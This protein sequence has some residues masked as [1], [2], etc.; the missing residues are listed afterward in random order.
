MYEIKS[1]IYRNGLNSS[2]IYPL[3]DIFGH[4]SDSSSMGKG[5][6]ELINGVLLIL[7][8]IISI[9]IKLNF[10]SL[11]RNKK[12][13]AHIF[14]FIYTI[15]IGYLGLHGA[16]LKD[17]KT[18][19]NLTDSQ[20]EEFKERRRAIES[21][22]ASVKSNL[23]ILLFCSALLINTSIIHIILNVYIIIIIKLYKKSV[24]LNNDIMNNSTNRN[25]LII[26]Q[27]LSE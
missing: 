22:F 5:I 1:Y 7:I 27:S 19:L 21:N 23:N 3:E 24:I 20:V 13:F 2:Y 18:K 15:V 11:N 6:A 12:I 26:E 9:A 25:N 10:I 16:I 17:K 14:L 4:Y 8:L